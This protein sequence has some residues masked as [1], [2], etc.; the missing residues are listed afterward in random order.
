MFSFLPFSLWGIFTL[1][2]LGD[3]VQVDFPSFQKRPVEPCTF[4]PPPFSLLMPGMAR[5]ERVRE[6]GLP[7]FTDTVPRPPFYPEWQ[8]NCASGY[9]LP[10]FFHYAL[11]KVNVHRSFFSYRG[12]H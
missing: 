11:F 1:D 4:P 5:L 2:R 9:K 6:Y 8:P 7:P 10:F 3:T 12:Q